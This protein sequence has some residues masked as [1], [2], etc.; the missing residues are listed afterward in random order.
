MDTVAPATPSRIMAA[1]R[2]RDTGPE[3]LLRLHL[4]A[5]GVGRRYRLHPR[6][7]GIRPD[8]VFPAAR[9][10]VFVDGCF[11]HCCPI[12]RRRQPAT[13]R[14][15]WIPK[16]AANA[17]RDT[18]ADRTLR[19][20]GWLVLRFWEHAV[21]ADPAACAASVAAAISPTPAASCG[22]SPQSFA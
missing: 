18:R 10:A 15:Y 6:V 7:G 8:I 9:L 14:E 12:C 20:A 17:A 4:R 11:W 5:A 3:V 13:N 16:L 19:K 21:A 22:H 2:S 1:I